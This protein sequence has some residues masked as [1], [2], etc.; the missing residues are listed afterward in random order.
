MRQLWSVA[1][2]VSLCALMRGTPVL[3]GQIMG[4][5][6]EGCGQFPLARNKS[7]LQ[8]NCKAMYEDVLKQ[9]GRPWPEKYFLE[10]CNNNNTTL[11][12]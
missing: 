10:K 5:S 6:L 11:L 9:P 12:T 2:Q 4:P 8:R 7:R 1:T 3:L